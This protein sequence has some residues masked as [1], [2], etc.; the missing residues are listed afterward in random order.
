[1]HYWDRSRNLSFS[2]TARTNTG[3]PTVA[4]DGTKH[5]L[6]TC[7]PTLCGSCLPFPLPRRQHVVLRLG[8][9]WF[10]GGGTAF[11]IVDM[12]RWVMASTD[13]LCW[14]ALVGRREDVEGHDERPRAE[15][16]AVDKA[17]AAIAEAFDQKVEVHHSVVNS[18]QLAGMV[19]KKKSLSNDCAGSRLSFW[20]KSQH[21]PKQGSSEDDSRPAIEPA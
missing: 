3:P 12:E 9:S 7:L 18:I 4:Q 13:D 5:L 20:W 21:P 16:D 10:V 19:L 11:F 14:L 6:S 17:G 2:R 1:M 15:R 8:V